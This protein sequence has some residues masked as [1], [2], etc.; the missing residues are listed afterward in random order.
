M[1]VGKSGR[2]PQTAVWKLAGHRGDATKR[3]DG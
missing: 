3:P 2:Y 1:V